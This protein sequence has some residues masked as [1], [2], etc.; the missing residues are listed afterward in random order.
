MKIILI[1]KGVKKMSHTYTNQSINGR[2]DRAF[3]TEMVDVSS[4]PI[5][6]NQRLKSMLFTAF[7]LDVQY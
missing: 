4:I 2:V 7:L 6:S 5:G 3:S 1:A